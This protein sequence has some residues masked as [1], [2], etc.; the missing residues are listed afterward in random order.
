MRSIVRPIDIAGR[1]ADPYGRPEW[2]REAAPIGGLGVRPLSA[3]LT[4][5]LVARSEK[6]RAP[7]SEGED[8]KGIEPWFIE[9]PAVAPG[10]VEAFVGGALD[11][12]RLSLLVEA[13]L[14]LRPDA[15]TSHLWRRHDDIRAPIV[16]AWRILAPFFSREVLRVGERVVRLRPGSTW[17]R[18][19]DSGGVE[20]VLTAAL[21]RWKLAGLPPVYRAQ[22]IS[23]VAKVDG[24]SLAA[25]LL[26]IPAKA[27]IDGDFKA[28]VDFEALTLKGEAS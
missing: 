7:E 4:D 20:R 5:V 8:V 3:V 10:D 19:L 14:L 23:L 21:L 27:D 28:V 6:A 17:A 12:P 22:S 18:E 9:G 26:C 15:R 2:T 24:V 1:G 16:P 25:S 11:L 13:L